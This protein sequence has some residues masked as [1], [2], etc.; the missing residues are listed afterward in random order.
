MDKLT[1]QYFNADRITVVDQTNGEVSEWFQGDLKSIA[2]LSG[3]PADSIVKI[4]HWMNV[5]YEFVATGPNLQGEMV[6]R[7]LQCEGI[8]QPSLFIKNTVFEL[9]AHLRRKKLGAR[10][11]AIELLE[12]QRTGQFA[13]VEVLAA[14]NASTLN[15]LNARDYLNGYVVWPQLGFDGPVPANRQSELYPHERVSQVLSAQN[16]PATWVT[17]G[18]YCRLKFDL[19]PSSASWVVLN[20]YL[21]DNGIEV[22]P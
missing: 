14:G 2:R 17:H 3:A 13:Y 8:T 7:I 19:K 16:G 6:R 20:R 15:P 1:Q 10:S 22:T 5:G 21:L 9:P 18:D 12:A 11:L 4:S